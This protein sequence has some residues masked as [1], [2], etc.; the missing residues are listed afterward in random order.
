L[1]HCSNIAY[2]ALIHIPKSEAVVASHLR[3]FH[4]GQGDYH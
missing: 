1:A 2:A 3:K 4:S